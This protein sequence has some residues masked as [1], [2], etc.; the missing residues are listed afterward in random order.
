MQ[1][2]LDKLKN[3]QLVW[4]L[5]AVMLAGVLF[6]STGHNDSARYGGIWWLLPSPLIHLPEFI[7]GVLLGNLYLLASKRLPGLQPDG[8]TAVQSRGAALFRAPYSPV[9]GWSLRLWRWPPCR[10]P[11]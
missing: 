11:G 5:A 10:I 2:L 8:G 1:T 9:R 7:S 3:N 6:N 4:T